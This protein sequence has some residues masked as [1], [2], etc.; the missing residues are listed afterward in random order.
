MAN[1]LIQIKRSTSTAAP[2]S[3]SFGE[4][5]YSQSSGV[6]YVGNNTTNAVA[7]GGHRNPGTL[8]AN[9]ALVANS[10][11][12]IDKVIVA[13]LV[14]TQVYANGTVGTGGYVL[15]SGAAGNVYWV[16]PS[17]FT[18]AAAGANTQIEFNDSGSFG[19]DANLTFDKTAVK[20][21]V[22]GA[23]SVG[24]GTSNAVTNTTLFTIQTATNSANLSA[25]GLAIGASLVNT[26]VVAVGSN[27]VHNASAFAIAGNTT[28][29]P[30]ATLQGTGLTVGNGT[31]TGAPQIIVAN[32]AGNVVINSTS[33]SVSTGYVQAANGLFSIG[34]F[35]GSYSDGIVVDYTAPS[36]R[37]S[38]GAADSLKFYADGIANTLMGTINTTGMFITGYVNASGF[39]TTGTSNAAT[40]NGT[41]AVNVGANV[42]LN[43]S[44]AF[45]GNTTSNTVTTSGSMTVSNTTFNTSVTPASVA[46]ANATYNFLVANTSRLAI[47]NSVA[48]VANGGV[49]TASQVLTSNGTGVYWSDNANGTVTSVATA[50][51]VG[52]G[53]IT[54]SGTLYVVANNGIVANTTG[55]WAKAANGISV[56]ASGINV[57]GSNGVV[58]NT[59]GVFL[60]TGSTMTLNATGLH[61]NNNLS[62]TDLTLSGNLTVSGTLTTVDTTNLTV[63]DPLIKVANGNATT[64]AVDV[65]IYGMFGNSTVTQYTGL[66]RDASDG[67]YKLFTG[68]QSEPSTTVNILGTGYALANLQLGA[69]TL[70]NPLLATSGG[71]GV[72]TY[73]KGD[74][75][76]SGAVNPSSLTNLALGTDGYVLT[77]NS[78]TGLPVWAS[79]DG[80]TF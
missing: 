65:G 32:S 76:I 42:T 58:S 43:T 37:I 10:T 14:P 70:T 59:S 16:N 50:N 64:D 73:A 51:G 4:L 36:G 75:L 1:N 71:V 44:A 77:A 46:I 35:N 79:L 69:L 21:T 31:I 8:T 12:G 18:T 49:G 20:F 5:A 39:S 17:T 74:I 53:T 52:G 62:I 56:D 68:L 29:A 24:T 3:L 30:T 41:T 78:T 63:K 27:V 13:N 40:F 60:Q 66:F 48:I 19:A 80:G 67:I 23:F 61:V 11:S 26:S 6:F 7:I 22:N 47:G 55:V 45:I 9:Q 15:A 38:V 72:N 28:T 33:I 2:V 57:V 34:Q 54:G 25:T